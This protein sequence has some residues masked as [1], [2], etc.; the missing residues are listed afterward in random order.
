MGMESKAIPDDAITASGVRS[1]AYH[2]SNARLN[3]GIGGG[4]WCAPPVKYIVLPI[5]LQVDLEKKWALTAVATQSL[6]DAFDRVATYHISTTYDHK[7]W[8]FV[9]D[10]TGKKVGL[11]FRH[12]YP[13]FSLK[14]GHW[15]LYS[16]ILSLDLAI[17][18][19]NVL[20]YLNILIFKNIQ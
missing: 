7:T 2:P 18:Q 3:L 11:D 5:Y 13:G 10:F 20:R 15:D 12:C 14:Q 19:E 9:H 1:S 6:K 17:P 8:V 4:G 16:A